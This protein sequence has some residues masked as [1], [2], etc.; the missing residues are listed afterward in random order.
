MRHRQPGLVEDLVAV[1]EQVEVD[2]PGAPAGTDS[3]PAEL[4]LDI[5]QLVEERPRRELRLQLGDRVQ[6]ERLL[7]VSPWLGLDHGGEAPGADQVGG[8]P[9]QR[10]AVAEVRAEA[11]VDER[12][13][14][15]TLTA[16]YST[17]I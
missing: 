7:G 3:L 6:E 1:E 9:D 17:V 5:E 11:D 15:S 13:G 12:H 8:A 14:R 10:L 2:R 16:P 4:P